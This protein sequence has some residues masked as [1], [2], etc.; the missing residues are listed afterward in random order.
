[1]KILVFGATGKTGKL[2]VQQALENG[3]DVTAFV[4]DTSKVLIS[5]PRLNVV[6]GDVMIS[7]T[8]DG[9]MKGHDAVICCLGVPA[10]KAGQL[11]SVGTRHIVESMKKF[12][13]EKFIC[14][15]SLGYA[16]SKE[17]LGNTSFFF[18]KFIV[19]M[20]LEKTFKEHELQEDI[21]KQSNLNW[22]IARPGNMTNGKLTGN[23]KTGFRSNDNS[24]KVKISRADTAH[25]LV[26][27][28]Y[29]D[30]NAKKVIGISY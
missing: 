19:P 3:F 27:Q 11:R 2:V 7:S 20:L 24:I 8:I 17:I 23:Y 16:D 5:H 30:D 14:Q 25:F 10:N 9:V 13:V 29:S 1:M 26:R 22:I 15:T 4:R 12:G 18:R 6:K 28:L 21:I